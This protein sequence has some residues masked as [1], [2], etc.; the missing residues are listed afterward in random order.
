[1]SITEL[2]KRDEANHNT[3]NLAEFIEQ[4]LYDICVMT[5]SPDD[6]RQ[7]V[8]GIMDL[9]EWVRQQRYKVERLMAKKR[10]DGMPHSFDDVYPSLKISYSHTNSLEE[11]YPSCTIVT[12]VSDS[13]A[14]KILSNLGLLNNNQT[15][16]D[17][18]KSDRWREADSFGGTYQRLEEYPNAGGLGHTISTKIEGL[19]IGVVEQRLRHP[20]QTGHYS[21]HAYFQS[22]I[23]NDRLRQIL[24][25]PQKHSPFARK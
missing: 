15:F 5:Q 16:L 1:M 7:L 20:Y 25:S 14:E 10:A 18:K 17:L 13:V 23:G 21:I 12:G 19:L 24:E 2:P 9:G 6:K 3:V 11:I 4:V 22:P 8:L